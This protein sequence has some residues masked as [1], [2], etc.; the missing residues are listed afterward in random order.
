MAVRYNTFVARKT[1]KQNTGKSF[2]SKETNWPIFHYKVLCGQ[3][4]NRET[5]QLMTN[6]PGR[7]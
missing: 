2:H 7:R 3:L 5:T 4:L 6:F 1:K